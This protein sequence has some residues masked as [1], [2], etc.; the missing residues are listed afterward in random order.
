MAF[1]RND[2][3]KSSTL[4]AL[5]RDDSAVPVLLSTKMLKTPA[6]ISALIQGALTAPLMTVS[7]FV[8][9]RAGAD[10]SC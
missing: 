7:S 10:E 6:K 5:S 1:D 9:F 3:L 4:V 8:F 2:L